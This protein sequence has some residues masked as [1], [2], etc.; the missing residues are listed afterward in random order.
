MK[1]KDLFIE[2]FKYVNE[3]HYILITTPTYTDVD[4]LSS[5]LS[6]SNYFFENKIKHKVFNE[7]EELPRKLNFLSKY[8]KISSSLPQFY[9]LVI[10]LGFNSKN[11]VSGFTNSTCKTIVINNCTLNNNILAHNIIDV[12]RGST[13][14]LLYD[15]YK[16]NNLKISKKAA[17]CL[18]IG[19]YDA[20]QAFSSPLT[21]PNTF[22]VVTDL[23]NCKI[24]ISEIVNNL[25]NRESLAT[26]KA[27][28]KIMDTLDLFCEGKIATIHLE[29][30]CIKETG[31]LVNDCEDII[32]TVL[33]IGIVRVVAYFKISNDIIKVSV[34]SKNKID[35]SSI[36]LKYK[37][38]GGIGFV[39]FKLSS[40]LIEQSKKEVVNTILNYI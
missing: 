14:E 24:N 25:K 36:A 32:N 18:Y 31:V 28:S 20:S 34:K 35:M 8:D 23:L 38:S 30:Y 5:A 19:I 15:F 12:E 40:T 22:N 4:S 9:D 3:A 7:G 1:N 10:Y 16:Y 29:E 11:K 21:L 37:G 39:E 27:L 26:F 6:L 13:S 17:E 2:M 33:S